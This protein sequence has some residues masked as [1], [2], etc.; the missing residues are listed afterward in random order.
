MSERFDILIKGAK[1]I[2]GTGK[3]AFEGSLGIRGEK[4]VAVGN[5]TGEAAREIDGSGL[6]IC[7]GF[8]DIHSHG[9][10]NILQYPLAENLVMQGVTTFAGGNCGLSLAP[11]NGFLPLGIFTS[12][13]V[14]EWWHE[15]EPHTYG[16]PGLLPLDKYGQILEEKLGYTI[17]WKTFGE[18]L[19]KVERAGASVNYAPLVGYNTVRL[20]A[21]GEDFQRKAKPAEIEAMKTYVDEAMKS[22][23]FGLGA[24]FDGFT[25]DFAPTEEVIEVAKA[26]AKHGGFYASHGRNTDNNYPSTDP[27]EWGY[28]ICHNIS[29]D[30]IPAAKY[31]STLETIEVARKARM[32]GHISHAIPAYTIYQYYP[33]VLQEAATKATLELVDKAREEGLDITLDI[34]PDED[35]HGVFLSRPG[36]IE[37][38]STWLAKLGSRERFVENLKIKDFRDELR[39]EFTGGRFKILM[40]HPKTDF[41]WMDRPVI[42]ACKNKAY[43]GKTIGEI[44]REK[45]ADPFDTLLDIVIEDPD[46]QYNC[47]DPRWTETSVATF[48]RYPATMVAT[49]LTMVPFG[50]TELQGGGGIAAGEPGLATY[51]FFPRYIRR[52]VKEKAVLSLE[53]AVKKA[54]SLPAQRLGLKDRGIIRSGACADVLIFDAEKI[55]D[56]GTWL[57]PRVRPEGILNVIVNGEIVY[58]NMAHT[59]AKSGKVLRHQ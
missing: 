25:G 11:I 38:F 35:L 52:F 58:E 16:P 48:L 41:C 49:D 23:A 28:G 55:R 10:V 32:P 8:I 39:R 22:G 31:W 44:A 24:G 14:G 51:A 1:I 33:D 5:V 4:I 13:V 17:D 2:D 6:T 30:E 18:F 37:L 59:G 3:S 15:V 36:L 27:N 9:D 42:M 40:I 19:T 29:P 46:T 12:S 50:D 20:A 45:N 21:M 56:K 26:A 34:L 47:R 7:P 53:E 43:E 54:T 57:K